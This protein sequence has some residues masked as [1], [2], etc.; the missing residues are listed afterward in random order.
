MAWANEHPAPYIHMVISDKPDDEYDV[1]QLRTVMEE[2]RSKGYEFLVAQPGGEN[3]PPLIEGA[4]K[5][6][7]WETFLAG[8]V[9]D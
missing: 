1:G 5:V 9:D 8:A 2:L 7:E 4:K 6:W 3:S